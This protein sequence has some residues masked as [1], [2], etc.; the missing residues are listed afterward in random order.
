[1]SITQGG[2]LPNV[3]ETTTTKDTSPA[4]YQTYL[5]NIAAAGSGALTKAGAVG[6]DGK[7]TTVL[8]TGADLVAGYD[9]MQSLGY[10]NLQTAVG[11]YQPGLTAAGQTA[12]RAAQ[13]ITPERIQSLM[14][15]YTTNVVNEMARLSN[16]NVERNLM[17]GLKAGFV[18]TGGL[19]SQRYAGALGQ[20]L[21]DIQ[22]TLTGQQT[23][24]L[25]AGYGQ[26]LKGAL[27]E[28][29]LMNAAAKTQADI[30]KQEQELGIAG[31]GALTKA[32]AERQKYQQSILD[33]PLSMAK[34]ASSL[35][36]GL[37]MPVDQTKTATGPK[38]RDYYQQSDL[39]KLAGVLSMIGGAKEGKEGEGLNKLLSILQ[40]TGAKGGSIINSLLYPSGAATASV[41]Q[42]E[43]DALKAAGV[44]DDYQALIT[45]LQN[46]YS[47]VLPEDVTK[48]YTNL[49][50]VLG[51]DDYFTGP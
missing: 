51:E 7:P 15:P 10:N 40:N 45:G 42:G 20:S 2:P 26:A 12:G 46:N 37:T 30:A 28:A 25:S 43:I 44:Y 50:N 23:G 3:T 35:M 9:P 22:A 1:M 32:G 4:G 19:G 17:P 49:F 41:G 47:D 16:Q 39:G 21:A 31:A 27:D 24:A 38:T 36:R 14:N 33:A 34:E 11:A 13:G 18:G 29:Q 5:E 8:K 48:A 6:A